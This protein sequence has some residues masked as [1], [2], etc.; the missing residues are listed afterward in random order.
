MLALFSSTLNEPQGQLTMSRERLLN[1]LNK[2]QE[3]NAAV[4]GMQKELTALQPTLQ[5]K[6]ASAEQLL[7]QVRHRLFHREEQI[8][9]AQKFGSNF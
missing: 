6:T 1:R 4:D 3:T 9:L 7:A 8:A 5:L 2:L